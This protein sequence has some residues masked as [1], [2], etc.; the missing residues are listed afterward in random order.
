MKLFFLT[1]AVVFFVTVGAGENSALKEQ[2]GKEDRVLSEKNSNAY[3]TREIIDAQI[4]TKDLA[5]SQLLRAVDLRLKN[6][7]S[8]AERDEVFKLL[9]A[10][11]EKI[12]QI[13]NIPSSGGSLE[14]ALY[15]GA[16]A[17]AYSHYTKIMMMDKVEYARW[18][19]IANSLVDLGRN[20][21][22]LTDGYAGY[23]DKLYDGQV[24]LSVVLR[25]QYIFS[26]GNREFVL[27]SSD[28]PNA[29][30]DDFS[31]VFLCE[32]Q[33]DKLVLRYNFGLESCI[34]K[35]EFKD[36]TLKLDTGHRK[37]SLKLAK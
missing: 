15:A 36:N 32:Y 14:P 37:V 34:N 1:A 29:V 5:A 16:I 33:K 12:Q 22:W 28:I 18:K 6:C 11:G 10:L 17:G 4:G 27:L 13:R 19:R 26:C 8:Q 35:F 3:T 23:T 24:T 20:S 21:F 2:F 30:C 9:I 7:S 31:Q 25:P